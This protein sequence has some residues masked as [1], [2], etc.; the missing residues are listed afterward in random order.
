MATTAF[1]ERPEPCFALI[2][3]YPPGQRI[4]A[5]KSG[6][7]GYFTTTLDNA[8]WSLEQARAVVDRLDQKLLVSEDQ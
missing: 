1:E 2:S 5:I 4:V 3:C 6:E 8:S 7:S